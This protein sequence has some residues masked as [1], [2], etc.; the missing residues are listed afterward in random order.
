MAIHP[1]VRLR[2]LRLWDKLRA[3]KTK[4]LLQFLAPMQEKRR[5][6]GRK[7]L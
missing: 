4:R 2:S 6:P 1:H 5:N 7:I 3:Q